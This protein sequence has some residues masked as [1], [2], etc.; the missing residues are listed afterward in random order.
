VIRQLALGD[1]AVDVVFKNIKNVHL[2]VHPPS[3]RVRISAPKRMS[4]GTIRV[5]AISK[6]P[7]IQR[8]RQRLR[9]QERET[10]REFVERESHFVWGTRYLLEISERPQPPAIEL[11]E[12][13]MILS[14][15]P[16]TDPA[17]RE[18][19]VARWYRD[20][21]HDAL[22]ELLRKWEPILAVTVMGVRVRRMKTRW[23]TCH[24]RAR[25]IRLN[26]ELAKKPKE[27][28]EYVVVHELVHLLE[29]SHNARFVALMDT[30]LPTWRLRRQDLNRF[31]VRDVNWEC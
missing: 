23:G 1:V 13:R 6:L 25:T 12:R 4:L 29:P 11:C 21:V 30:F 9:E 20:L 2:S 18:A 19:I 8:Q 16:G 28:L 26:S 7:W 17:R 10:R 14:V 24:P 27:C 3:G 22:P 5:F 31:P 15:R